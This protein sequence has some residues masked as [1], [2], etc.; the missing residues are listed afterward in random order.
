MRPTEVFKDSGRRIKYPLHVALQAGDGRQEAEPRSLKIYGCYSFSVDNGREW[1]SECTPI[2]RRAGRC[3]CRPAGRQNQASSANISGRGANMR[4]GAQASFSPIAYARF[5]APP[6]RQT[7]CAPRRRRRPDDFFGQHAQPLC[8]DAVSGRVQH[9]PLA[10]DVHCD[11]LVQTDAE[12]VVSKSNGFFS[13]TSAS[14]VKTGVPAQNSHMDICVLTPKTAPGSQTKDVEDAFDQSRDGPAAPHLRDLRTDELVSVFVPADEPADVALPALGGDVASLAYRGN[15]SAGDLPMRLVAYIR[16]AGAAREQHPLWLSHAVQAAGPKALA[17]AWRSTF[18]VLPV[19]RRV[20]DFALQCTPSG[21]FA[22]CSRDCAGFTGIGTLLVDM[23]S[24]VQYTN[25]FFSISEHSLPLLSYHHFASFILWNLQTCGFKTVVLTTKTPQT[26]HEECVAKYLKRVLARISKIEEKTSDRHRVALVLGHRDA[27]S[28]AFLNECMKKGLVCGLLEDIEFRVPYVYAHILYPQ[29]LAAARAAREAPAESCGGDVDYRA[30]KAAYLAKKFQFT[31]CNAVMERSVCEAV[32]RDIGSDDFFFDGRIHELLQLG[33][34]SVEVPLSRLAVDGEAYDEPPTYMFSKYEEID[35]RLVKADEKR[36]KDAQI[37]S[38][39][40]NRAA[41]SLLG[42]KLL[43][44]PIGKAVSKREKNE[45]KG[46]VSPKQLAMIRENQQRLE[47]EKKAKEIEFLRSFYQKYKSSTS[48]QRRRLLETFVESRSARQRI[49][50]LKI[51]FYF[52]EWTL[53]K[54]K[55]SPDEAVLVPCYLSCLEFIDL[56][57]Q[58]E[59]EASEK[60]RSEIKYAIDKLIECG[61]KATAA[62]LNEKHGLGFEIAHSSA[63]NDLDLYFQ[64]KFAGDKLKRSTG[65]ARDRR[66]LFEPDKWQTALLDLVDENKSVVV[67]APTSSG[68]TFICFYAI[69]KILRNSDT[70][71]VVFCLPTKALVNQVSI[72][73]YA[74]FNT[75]IFSRKDVVLQGQLL[76]DY[77]INALNCQVLLTIPSMLEAVHNK[78]RDRIKYIIIDEI[79]LISN[80]EMGVS[81]E[82]AI[83]M[84]SAPLLLLSATLNNLGSFYMWVKEL[85]SRKGRECELIVYNERYCDLKLHVYSEGLNDLNPLFAYSFEHIRDFGFSNDL[86]FLPSE[87]LQIYYA[88]YAALDKGQKKLIQEMRPANFFES[89]V[90]TKADVI[91]YE[92]FILGKFKEWIDCGILGEEQVYRIYSL[93]TKE[94]SESFRKLEETHVTDG[95][96]FSNEYLFENVFDLCKTLRE[97]DL[98]PCIVFNL[99]REVCNRMA[100]RLYRELEDAE[101]R[102]KT[103]KNE[104]KMRERFLKEMK[105][106]RDEE[107]KRDAWMEETPQD[108]EN[109]RLLRTSKK[110]VKHTFLTVDKLS[111]YELEEQTRYLRKT[112]GCYVD[113]LWRGIGIHHNGMNKSYRGL[114]EILFRMKHLQIVF[115]TETLSLGINM[116]CRTVVFAGDSLGLTP[117][118]YKQMAGR[119][120][121]R[122]FDT[123]GNVIFYGICKEKVQNLIISSLPNLKAPFSY[124]YGSFLYKIDESI[125]RN[126]LFLVNYGG[127]CAEE[128]S[129]Y[130]FS[131]VLRCEEER[132]AIVDAKLNYLR[133]RGFIRDQRFTYLADI[134]AINKDYDTEVVV[135]MAVIDAG[136]VDISD[137]SILFVLMFHLFAVKPV[138]DTEQGLQSLPPR[139]ERFIQ[140]VSRDG[141]MLSAMERNNLHAMQF[142]CYNRRPLISMDFRLYR[143]KSRYLWSYLFDNRRGDVGEL[144][145]GMCVIDGVFKSIHSVFEKYGVRTEE[146]KIFSMHYEF[147]RARFLTLHA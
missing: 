101:K 16:T 128:A 13:E 22:R 85:E 121:R 5:G 1:L 104:E 112:E 144:F 109:N 72:D 6:P 21:F 53:E 26:I 111:D 43:Y 55:E 138:L 34:K 103:D 82:R 35:Y 12:P 93:L 88:V 41:K 120:G 126:P 130:N 59:G 20:A 68:K 78:L 70:E 17:Q 125:L 8:A 146:K 63:P 61:F 141:A 24:L 3:V 32:L 98:L 77:Q 60:T 30:I 2:R 135:F 27:H 113:M 116:P 23:E 52:E 124:G 76:R 38:K 49:L 73:I 95:Y 145:K 129:E 10:R 25:D 42:D 84:S 102:E 64:M 69:E 96:S 67:S 117:L 119:A 66:V 90:L 133:R 19:G 136:L 127:G 131:S 28:V 86:N 33:E 143:N 106:C 137:R 39:Y 50:L 81:I 14:S 139:V 97:K 147:F 54:H 99:D 92:R 48:V 94:T 140:E 7:P 51:E 134:L 47:G 122:S 65:S 36:P 4:H 108:E 74:R 29:T 89:N 15:D 110:N 100:L 123:L 62:E 40:L 87:V 56:A 31:E 107:K 58:T 91:R 115:S 75:K 114:V 132:R 57:A 18:S 83:H 46:K 11:E 80:E 44:N 105:R 9:V 118:S 45:K 142:L 79:H 71:V 37:Y